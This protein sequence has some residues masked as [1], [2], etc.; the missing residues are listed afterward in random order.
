MDDF[1]AASLSRFWLNPVRITEPTAV[2]RRVE[3][4]GK[5]LSA[6]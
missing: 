6:R 4:T 2:S 1:Y 3:T 5:R